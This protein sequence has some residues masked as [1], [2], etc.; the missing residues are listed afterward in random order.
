[1]RRILKFSHKDLFGTKRFFPNNTLEKPKVSNV[2]TSQT[3]WSLLYI[4]VQTKL[5]IFRVGCL[6]TSHQKLG[7]FCAIF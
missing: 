2:F 4:T 1:M 6:K 5:G 3:S 7:A